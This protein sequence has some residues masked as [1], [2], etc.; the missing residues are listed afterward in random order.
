MPLVRCRFD[1]DEGF[2]VAYCYEIQLVPQAQRKGLGKFMMQVLE[3]IGAKNGME[4][5]LLTVMK[6]NHGARAM[7]SRLG[8]SMDESS[9]GFEDPTEDA[10]YEILSKVFK[11]K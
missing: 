7:Y 1:G 9:P 2:P 5:C 10:G 8:Y 6:E 3:L 11:R 4:R